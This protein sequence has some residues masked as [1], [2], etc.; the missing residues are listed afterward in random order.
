MTRIVFR[1]PGLVCTVLAFLSI[2][3]SVAAQ[4]NG[5]PGQQETA[6]LMTLIA[7]RGEECELLRPWQA[8]SLRIQTRDLIARLDEAERTSVS[9]SI[10]ARRPDMGCSDG[11]LV[12]WTEGAG[13]NFDVEYLPELLTAYRAMASRPSPPQPFLDAAGRTDFAP[14]M[15]RIDQKLAEL[16]AEGI[17]PPSDMTWPE[18]HERQ[19]S[20]AAE[21]AAA[22]EGT[23]ASDRF[24]PE[25]A[26]RIVRDIATIGE[27][28]L[29]DER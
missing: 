19:A 22:V 29:A 14:A 10:E 3:P 5:L 17:R 6:V 27:L 8:E 7:D 25:E 16:E 2:A 26:A 12:T 11:L 18:L 15:T 9:E 23:T 21:L 28:W 20:A 24:P 13:P 4:N 1:V